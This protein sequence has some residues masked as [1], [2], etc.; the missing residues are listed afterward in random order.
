[1][2]EIDRVQQ[3]LRTF[4]AFTLKIAEKLSLHQQNLTI[5]LLCQ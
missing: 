3:L 4:G 2:T 1:M 5:F